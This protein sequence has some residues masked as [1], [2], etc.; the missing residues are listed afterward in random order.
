MKFFWDI[1]KVRDNEFGW[2]ITWDKYQGEGD[3]KSVS[4]NWKTLTIK[5]V[6]LQ[7]KICAIKNLRTD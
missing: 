3:D 1:K 7:L 6:K 5:W 4:Y 2:S